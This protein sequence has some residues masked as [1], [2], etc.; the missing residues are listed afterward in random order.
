MLTCAAVFLVLFLGAPLAGRAAERPAVPAAAH[1]VSPAASHR[2]A[3]RSH[4]SVTG[5]PLPR[6][7]ALRANKVNMRVGPGLRYPIKWVYQRRNMPV[8]IEREFYAWRYV[9]DS[10]GIEGWMHGATLVG[11][12]TFIVIGHQRPLRQS[13]NP[14]APIIARLNPGVVGT[15]RHCAAGGAQCE[16]RVAGYTGWL[17]RHSFWGARPGEAIGR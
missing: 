11:H 1:S 15:V 5:L 3:K 7:A 13:A 10:D 16:V 4:G 12:H 8:E 17:D 2:R 9:R 14:H 6:F